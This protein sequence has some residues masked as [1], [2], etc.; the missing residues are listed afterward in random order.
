[1]PKESLIHIKADD[2]EHRSGVIDALSKTP[3]VVVMQQR[4][5]VGDYMINDQLIIERKTLL[6]FAI[7]LKSG[8]LFSQ[9]HR[10]STNKLH[11]ILLLEGNSQDLEG[12]NMRREAIQGALIHISLSMHIPILR[13]LHP[14]ESAQLMIYL[15]R[16]LDELSSPRATVKRYRPTKLK[17]KQRNQQYL[18]QGLPG[19]G[20]SRARLLLEK[21]GSVE[22][23]LLATEAELRDVPGIGDTVAQKIRWIVEESNIGYGE[24][25]ER[26]D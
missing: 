1:M 5:P 18:L 21:F 22:K 24:D 6:D 14:E 25:F 9:L 3:G 10:L 20:P 2:R 11:G 19:I 12:S 13:S 26:T 15:A 16:Q 8:R 4:L 23:V 7:S 17:S